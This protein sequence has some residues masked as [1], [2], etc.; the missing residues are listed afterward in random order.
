MKSFT[1]KLGVKEWED[2]LKKIDTLN[3]SDKKYSEILKQEAKERTDRIASY[4]ERLGEEFVKEKESLLEWL[5]EGKQETILKEFIDAKGLGTDDDEKTPKVWVHKD[6]KDPS[7]GKKSDFEK[8]E[9]QWAGSDSLIWE[10]ANN[11]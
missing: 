9:E 10:M 2:I 1:E 7:D 4:K 5:D 3:D 11:I 6:G 8:L